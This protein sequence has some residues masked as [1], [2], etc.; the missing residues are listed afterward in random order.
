MQSGASL[1]SFYS[2]ARTPGDAAHDA[3]RTASCVLI[4]GA[5]SGLGLATAQRLVHEG[6]AVIGIDRCAHTL[7]QLAL[8]MGYRFRPLVCDVTDPRGVEEAAIATAAMQPSGIDAIVHFAGLHAAGALMDMGEQEFA[9]VIDVNVVGV[10][11]TQRAFF[12]LLRARRGKTILISSEVARARF[13]HAFSG[14]YAVSKCCL[15]NFA[16]VLRQEL[17]CLQPPMA[18]TVLHLGQF[19]T[20]LLASAASGFAVAAQRAPHSVFSPALMVGDGL[21]RWYTHPATSAQH[22]AQFSPD[23]CANKVLEVLEVSWPRERYALNVS[24]L[25]TLVSIMPVSILNFVIVSSIRA[26]LYGHWKA[27]SEVVT[28]VLSA[29]LMIL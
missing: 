21:A 2:A 13:C 24:W 5:A 7:D 27:L 4:T 11:R 14:A 19:T 1:G 8:Q 25:M 9:A 28:A 10:W 6:I 20:P 18:V 23:R 26:K 29:A 16:S 22:S 3:A 15:D 17:A 12:D